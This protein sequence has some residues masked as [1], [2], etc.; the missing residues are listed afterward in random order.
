M[1][2]NTILDGKNDATDGLKTSNSH[3]YAQKAQTKSD[4]RSL[5]KDQILEL[6]VSLNQ[7]KFR[8]K[9]IEDWIWSKGATSFDQMSNL[10]KTLRE[11][12]SKK[13]SL[14]GAQQIVRQVSED[15]SRKYLL[16]YPDGTS[17]ECVGM[18]SGNKLSV[19]AS[20][21]AGC[22]MG[23]A[24]C[25]TGAAGLTRSLSASE[26]Y[27]QVMHIRN[28]FDTRV[29]SV[30]LMGQGEPFMNYDATL[31]AMRLLNSPEG[32]SIGA[33]HITVST[34]GVIPMIKRFAAE[35]EQ[36]TLAVSLHSAVQKTRDF[37]MPGVKKYSLIHLYD[38]MGEYV[39]KTGRRPTYEYALIK[40]INDSDN[41]LGALR[42]FCRG[43]LCHVNIIQLNEIEGSKFHPT[44]P[45]R[46][47]EFINSLNS[48]GVEAT[49]RI[50]R[51][52]DIDAACGQLF[53]K[54][55]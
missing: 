5:S 34:C 13:V 14:E 35:P 27:E 2:S 53:Q 54:N 45:A 3:L 30:V 37:L 9:Q 28:D 4:L 23:C 11:E 33:R 10:P 8:A 49:I 29:T 6:V 36:F 51:G 44:S 46:A 26:I 18:P 19:C 20:T 50:S 12:L 48:V 15:G 47:Q 52:A 17:V 40:G 1:Q 39:D 16:R 31:D 55:R 38:I 42:D 24:F 7:P 22:A 25:A 43:T 21:Q 41:E 32:A